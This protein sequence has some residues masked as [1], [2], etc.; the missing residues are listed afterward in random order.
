MKKIIA[1]LFLLS[2][3]Q[4]AQGMLKE[5]VEQGV[6]TNRFLDQ[7]IGGTCPASSTSANVTDCGNSYINDV[8]GV[9]F[10]DPSMLTL[11]TYIMYN[12]F[13]TYIEQMSADFNNTPPPGVN[14]ESDSGDDTID[15]WSTGLNASMDDMRTDSDDSSVE[16]QSM[17]A[18]F[19]TVT[20]DDY[21]AVGIYQLELSTSSSVQKAVLPDLEPVEGAIKLVARLRYNGGA[22]NSQDDTQNIYLWSQHAIYLK[23]TDSFKIVI[24]NDEDNTATALSSTSTDF[25]ASTLAAYF[26][27]DDHTTA[28]CPAYQKATN[29]PRKVRLEIV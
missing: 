7:Y 23:P 12:D 5:F 15:S 24:S 25:T 13:G 21:P 18:Q 16:A 20:A 4:P 27:Y 9:N 28:D 14:R 8:I 26:Q 2:I 3:F 11:G 22:S 6:S 17:Q 1:L 10:L 29:S 19:L